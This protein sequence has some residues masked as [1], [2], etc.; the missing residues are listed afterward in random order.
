MVVAL[1]RDVQVQATNIS[2]QLEDSSAYIQAKEWNNTGAGSAIPPISVLQYVQVVGQLRT[3]NQQR[4][5]MA[6]SIRPVVDLNQVTAHYLHCLAVHT[7]SSTTTTSTNMNS[8]AAAG[9]HKLQQQLVKA[10]PEATPIHLNILAT[11]LEFPASIEG[12]HI[13]AALAPK[14]GMPLPRLKEALQ[15]MMDQGWIYNTV[16]DDLIKVVNDRALRN[17]GSLSFS[18]LLYFLTLIITG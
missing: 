17:A 5:L 13:E 1:V 16:S 2:Y 6:F 14:L 10:F 15:H 18:S 4:I 11:L 7:S 8:T 12:V 3:F 9:S